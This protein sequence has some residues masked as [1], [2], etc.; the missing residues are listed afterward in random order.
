MPKRHRGDDS[1]SLLPLPLPTVPHAPFGS[2]GGGDLNYPLEAAP[3]YPYDPPMA[4]LPPALPLPSLSAAPKQMQELDERCGVRFGVYRPRH[5]LSK[6]LVIDEMDAVRMTSFVE[7]VFI[8]V[9]CSPLHPEE[10][11]YEWARIFFSD[12]EAA[13]LTV[14]LL[15]YP[16]RRSKFT[17]FVTQRLPL[18]K[19]SGDADPSSVHPVSGDQP[20]SYPA[21]PG[22][23][24]ADVVDTVLLRFADGWC[25]ASTLELYSTAGLEECLGQKKRGLLSCCEVCGDFNGEEM[26]SGG[27]GGCLRGLECPNAHLRKNFFFKLLVPPLIR[28]TDRQV[29]ATNGNDSAAATDEVPVTAAPPQCRSAG[30]WLADRATDTLIVHHLPADIDLSA[31]VYMF[32]RCPGYLRAQTVRAQTHVRYGVVWFA[33]HAAAVAARTEAAAALHLPILF[34]GEKAEHAADSEEGPHGK[35]EPSTHTEAIPASKIKSSVASNGSASAA[36]ATTAAAATSKSSEV[37][38]PPLPEGWEFGLSRRTMQYFFLQ[39]GKKSTTWKHPVT[40][41]RYS[42]KR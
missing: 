15:S 23:Q 31:F 22:A 9:G 28:V 12:A 38:F 34:Y 37:P 35:S 29:A 3:L 5:R 39:T 1:P 7:H 10:T 30:L 16:G 11:D 17:R 24:P 21:T 32:S 33:D 20:P 6:E 40:Q 36:V 4:W 14:A 8:E 19:K 13:E 41:E 25:V 26:S 2:G 42:A 27:S 18:P